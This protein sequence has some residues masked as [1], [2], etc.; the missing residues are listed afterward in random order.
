M[1]PSVQEPAK[2][3]EDVVR[4]HFD[5]I[6]I[7]S[8][9]VR[10]DNDHD[11]D[12]ILRVYVVVDLRDQKIDGSRLKGLVRHVRSALT[13]QNETRFPVFTFMTPQENEG[14]PEAA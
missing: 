2:S 10:E 12:P 8:V 11:G 6:D 3:I 1:Q 14:H 13:L 7:K 9:L 4:A 5:Q